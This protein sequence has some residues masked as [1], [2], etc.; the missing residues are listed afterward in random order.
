MLL[1]TLLLLAAACSA[2]A[3][4]LLEVNFAGAYQPVTGRDRVHGVL[5]ARWR[6]NSEFGRTWVTYT[7]V[8]E[9]G[10]AFLRAD[11]TKIEDGHCQFLSPLAR[12]E[13]ETLYKLSVSLRNSDHLMIQMGVRRISAPYKFLWDVTRVFP[14]GWS[15]QEFYLRIPKADF[16]TGFYIVI[17]GVGKLDLARLRMQP[18]TMA[19]VREARIRGVPA[20][21]PK[22]LV[23]HSTFPLGLQTGWSLDR[24][25]SDGDEIEIGPGVEASLHIKASRPMQLYT[26]PFGIRDLGAVH[27]ASIYMRGHGSG[28]LLAIAD[29]HVLARQQFQIHGDEWQRVQVRFTPDILARVHGL[30]LDGS[31]EFLLQRLQVER[32]DAA[33]AFEPPGACEVALAASDIRVQ[34]DDE[35][36]V[37]RWATTGGPQ[38]RNVRAKVFDIYGESRDAKPRQDGTLAYNV[39][40]ARPY[41]SFRIEAWVADRAGRTIS[42]VNELVVHRLHRPHYWMKD[43]PDSPFGTHT[44]STRRHILMAKAVGI[45][46]VRLHDA[47]TPYIGWYHLERKPGQWSFDD[48]SLARYRKYGLKILGAYSTAPEWASYFEKPH[49]GY[50]DRYYQPRDLKAFAN[51]VTVVTKRYAGVIDTYDLWNEPWGTGYW[52][53][54]YDEGRQA[55][56]ASKQGPAE[57]ARLMQTA[58][59][60][61]K[62]ADPR[63]TVLGVQSNAGQSGAAWTRGIVAADAVRYCDVMCY[64]NYSTDAAGYPGD[65]AELGVRSAFEPL[66]DAAGKPSRP[67]WMTEGSGT[68]GRMG[69]GLY[70][71]TLPYEEDE[72]AI[73]TSDRLARYEVATLARGAAKVFLYSMH[74]HSWFGS[75][76]AWRSLVTEEGYLHPSAAA[77]SAM[78]WF[79]EDTKIVKSESPAA[80]VTSFVFEG[81]GRVVTVLVPQPKHD[82]YTLPAAGFDLFGNP[83]RKGTPLGKT[84]VYL[85][86][87]AKPRNLQ[88]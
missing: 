57:F 9:Q 33:T 77:H 2:P 42:P 8:E 73:D 53:V 65:S 15:D 11:V 58:W 35:P 26:A 25:S 75:G 62:A 82:A 41:G 12:F 18:V 46:W 49:N 80:G 29:L 87:Q 67:F 20:G 24:E 16:D 61:A 36:A 17:K 68:N 81:A 56:V 32:G 85:I 23:R 5:P 86:G 48:A 72:D 45:N 3:E 44:N 43:A 38:C 30:R 1:R 14:A 7:R 6:D 31:G 37:V 79:L 27:T 76:N 51:Y 19:E 70:R 34:F 47:G 22:N 66:L 88:N 71:H 50:Y 39:F 74:S 54:G 13:A 21:G 78:A 40:R 10:R 52:G 60:A 59:E 55:Y 64:H 83:L 84:L 63:V 28:T 4:T 69:N